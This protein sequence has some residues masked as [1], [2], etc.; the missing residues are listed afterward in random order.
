MK[1]KDLEY[2][3]VFGMGG[4]CSC[5]WAL[6]RSKLQ[7]ASYPFDWVARVDLKGRT[8]IV[9]D[10]FRDWLLEDQMWFEAGTQSYSCD[11][12]HNRVTG[13]GF[14]HDFPKGVPIKDSFASVQEKYRRRIDRLYA[15]IRRSKRV[16]IVWIGFPEGGEVPREHIDFCLSTF[17]GKFPGVEFRMLVMECV[18][19]VPERR[20]RRESGDGFDRLSFDYE[21]HSKKGNRF[22]VNMRAI[23]RQL[24]GI[25]A[26]DTR[27]PEQKREYAKV[28]RQKRLRIYAQFGATTWLG[29]FVRRRLAKLRRHFEKRRAPSAS[30]FAKTYDAV[31]PMG[32]WC[33]PT[34]A[35]KKVGLRS[36]SGPFDWMGRDRPFGSYV[37]LLTTGFKGFFLKENMK[38]LGDVPGEGTEHW[39]DTKQGWEIRHEFKAGVPFDTNYANFHALVARRSER[40]FKS[41]R[42]GGRLLFAHWRAQGRYNREE[43]VADARRLR[44]AFPGTEIDLL[45]IETEK[46]A[47]GVSCEE[48]APGVVF[49]VGDFYDQERFD[50]VQGNKKLAQAVF[51]RIRMRGRL[52]NLLHL[53]TESVSRRMARILG[54]RK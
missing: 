29:Y 26:V 27:T 41:L 2:D 52:K 33:A 15:D 10:D 44:E 51:G 19:G 43:V 39:K 7:F 12:Y 16:L 54:R 40:L 21:D 17:R 32:Q 25:H 47:S 4:A 28:E 53:K 8:Q 50:P 49:A 31:W 42:S 37:D 11:I 3:L 46:F 18:R 9:A 48:P 34:M 45:V 5:S 14:N 6:R 36:A 35:M 1:D 24:R 13:I 20:M 30:V 23:C 38:K 22:Q